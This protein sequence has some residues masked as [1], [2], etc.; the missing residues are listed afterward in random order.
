MADPVRAIQEA[1]A[2]YFE[3]T[4]EELLSKPKTARLVY[5]RS[6]AMYLC[7]E[8]TRRS[9]PSLGRSFGNRD[10]TT[11]I[12]AEGKIRR[13][14]EQEDPQVERDLV[15]IR[16]AAL[17]HVEGVVM[18]IVRKAESGSAR[19]NALC[20]LVFDGELLRGFLRLL[21][22]VLGDDGA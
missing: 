14:V 13:A 9:T 10:H 18:Q 20:G 21:E 11:V 7:R 17:P 4:V 2:S 16:A 6:L 19:Y 5:A 15:A 12:H 3:M 1:T 22:W 8:M